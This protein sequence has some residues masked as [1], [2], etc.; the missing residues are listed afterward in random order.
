MPTMV[1]RW[2]DWANVLLGCWLAVSPWQLEYTLNKAATTNTCGL[3]AALIV[4][5]VISAC[6]IL[7]EGQEI[8]NVLFGVWLICSPYVFGFAADKEPTV[9][10]L[11]GGVI[12]VVLAIWQIHD[13][14]RSGRK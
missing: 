13:A 11:A 6:R 2:Q 8:L 1:L 12:V 3:G 9:N 7:D 10:A 5:N 4:F 14:V